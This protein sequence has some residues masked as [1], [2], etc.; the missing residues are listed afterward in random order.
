MPHPA[1]LAMWQGW[2]AALQDRL[3]KAAESRQMLTP[4][5]LAEMWDYAY[6]AGQVAEQVCR[7]EL[8]E[9]TLPSDLFPGTHLVIPIFPGMTREDVER[10]VTQIMDQLHLYH[11]EHALRAAARKLFREGR[12]NYAI[13]GLLGVAHPTVKAWLKGPDEL[14]RG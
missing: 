6:G 10:G 5:L 11:G 14:E 7:H 4:E 12:S 3:D 13:A 2:G 8:L 1:D 9:A